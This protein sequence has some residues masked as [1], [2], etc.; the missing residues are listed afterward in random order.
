[1]NKETMLKKWVKDEKISLI[2]MYNLS[3]DKDYASCVVTTEDTIREWIIYGVK[4]YWNVAD[5]L[6]LIE[7]EPLAELFKFD[8]S[9]GTCCT[10]E[11]IY[12]KE[13]LMEILLN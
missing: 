12:T 2:D 9:A 8:Y 10:P 13:E 5:T 3:Y 6:K 7:Q 1:M 4:E 11:P